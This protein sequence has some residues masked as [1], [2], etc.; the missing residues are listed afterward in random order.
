MKLFLVF[1]LHYITYKLSM[2]SLIDPRSFL[3]SV[4]ELGEV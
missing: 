1:F 2:R 4:T 3:G